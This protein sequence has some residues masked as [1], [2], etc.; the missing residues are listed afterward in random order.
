MVR[1]ASGPARGGLMLT[2]SVT[3]SVCAKWVAGASVEIVEFPQLTSALRPGAKTSASF[4]QCRDVTPRPRPVRGHS[5]APEHRRTP[6]RF[7]LFQIGGR[8]RGVQ[9]HAG[10]SRWHYWPPHDFGGYKSEGAHC[11]NGTLLAESS[12]FLRVDE[13]ARTDSKAPEV[14]PDWQWRTP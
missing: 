1:D 10:V 5:K 8:V 2:I 11:N 6:R 4:V 14:L 9:F 3:A 13:C 12:E 7:A